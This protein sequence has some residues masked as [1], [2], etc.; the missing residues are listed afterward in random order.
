M[1]KMIFNLFFEYYSKMSDSESDEDDYSSSQKQDGESG[2][3]TTSLNP[4]ER[5]LKNIKNENN[6]KIFEKTISKLKLSDYEQ[7]N[8][9]YNIRCSESLS[10][11]IS[12]GKTS[13][14]KK[15]L[16]WIKKYREADPKLQKQ[17]NVE[18]NKIRNPV[19]DMLT[20]SFIQCGKCHS[21][22]I[23]TEIKQTRSADEGATVFCVCRDCKHSFIASGK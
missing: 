20:G 4:I 19:T 6:H 22:N 23:Q 8:F 12:S 7:R 11:S 2:Y 3:A 18:N 14:L 5:F 21:R 13:E 1:I 9:L 15:L 16:D 10:A 17:R